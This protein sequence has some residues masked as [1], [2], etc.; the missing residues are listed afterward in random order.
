MKRMMKAA[1]LTALL[2]LSGIF[3]V[4]SAQTNAWRIQSPCENNF[5]VE[6]PT[7]LYRVSWFEGKHGASLEPDEGFDDDKASYVALQSVP[8]MRQFGI[9]V[10]NVPKK[11]RNNYRRKDFGGWYFMIGGDDAEPTSEEVVRVNGLIGKEYVYAKEIAAD[12]YTRGRIFY[13]DGR[14]YFI[15]FKASAIEDLMSADA[16]RFLNSFRIQKR[17]RVSKRRA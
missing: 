3:S 2:T 7:P 13:A 9:V 11:E 15:V 14:L 5:S 17:Q 4:V 10:L 12:T 8:K 1:L 6:L 16:S